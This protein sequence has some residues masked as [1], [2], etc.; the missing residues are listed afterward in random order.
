M[1]PTLLAFFWR[2]AKC[3]VVVPLLVTTVLVAQQSP[4]P[5]TTGAGGGNDDC[6]QRSI[7]ITFIQ[8]AQNAPPLRPQDLQIAVKGT[9]ASIL[10]V[11]QDNHSPRVTLLIDSSGSMG[12]P[13]GKSPW[14]IALQTVK[15]AANAIP[16]QSSVAVGT[17]GEHVQVSEFRD[18]SSSLEQVL[19]WTKEQ[20]KGRTALFN[21]VSSTSSLFKA[22]QFGDAI[23]LVTD[24]DDNRSSVTLPQ[25]EDELIRRGIRVFVFLVNKN[26]SF[27]IP[28]ERRGPENMAELAQTTGG[29]L[30]SL[31]W[32]EEWFTKPD[33]ASLVKSIREQVESPYLMKLQLTS[34]LS[35]PAKLSI[36]RSHDP[37][38]YTIAY[39]RRLEPCS[40]D[41][42]K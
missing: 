19:A 7:P 38:A 9:S 5:A 41:T 13:N 29:S 21:A 40:K 37:K 31:P 2:L 16:P 6:L 18:R 20:P 39:P 24:G 42:A 10:S 15:F 3:W 26:G 28:E 27:H 36:T 12:P 14:G 33:A 30:I 22:P 25:L 17:F 11:A 35:K 8:N 1:R 34:R 32:S 23:Y 4:T